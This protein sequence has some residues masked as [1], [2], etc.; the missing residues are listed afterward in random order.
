MH[1]AA[2]F[3]LFVVSGVAIVFAPDALTQIQD[4]T[5]DKVHLVY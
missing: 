5:K 2:C 4:K 3:M 1:S